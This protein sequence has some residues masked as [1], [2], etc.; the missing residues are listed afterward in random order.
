MKV[1]EVGPS[2]RV[3]PALISA[4]VNGMDR[5][6]EFTIDAA[7]IALLR[8]N[9]PAARNALTWI[10]Q[11]E[12][13]AAVAAARNETIHALIITGAGGSFVSGGDLK[14]LA[15]HPEAPAAERL[16]R[17]MSG[18]LA[19][20]LDLPY[21]V[22][23]AVEG[24]AVGGGCEILT[25]CDLR[26]AGTGARLSFRQV[27]NGLTTGWGGTA[28]LVSLIGQSRA[29]EL[30]LTGRTIDAEEARAMGLIHRIVPPGNDVLEEAYA[31]AGEVSRLPRRALAAIKS[32][33]HA[34]V[35]LSL[36][37]ANALETQLF[38]NLW[39]SADHL[40]AMNA[41]AEKRPPVFNRE[42]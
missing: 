12:F 24:D 25:A 2:C 35:H 7:G 21:P 26:L 15:G 5:A 13:A 14:E 19:G 16:N 11:E 36:P 30:L 31:W 23:A 29:M 9:R 17:V 20:L 4:I 37:D 3:R 33:V 18:A 40:E 1:V 27:Q 42:P 38:I 34:A 8:V 28:R 41:F 10:A 6:I 32:L 39:P 22:I